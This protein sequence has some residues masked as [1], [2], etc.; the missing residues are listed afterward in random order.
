MSFQL[1]QG[2]GKL[3]ATQQVLGQVVQNGFGATAR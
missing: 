3:I 2:F 1:D